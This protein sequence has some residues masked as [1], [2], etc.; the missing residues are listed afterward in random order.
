MTA[1]EILR[2]FLEVRKEVTTRDITKVL[3]EHG[4]S[5]SMIQYVIREAKLKGW[6]K[7][8]A[9]NRRGTW[10]YISTLYEGKVNRNG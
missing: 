10:I 1:S 3:S 4:Y 2:S 7:P 6:I 8:K 5:L 9:R